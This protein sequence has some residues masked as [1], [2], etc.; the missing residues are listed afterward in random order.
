MFAHGAQQFETADPR[1]AHIADHGVV[2]ASRQLLECLGPAS[3]SKHSITALLQHPTQY[4][5]YRVIVVDEQHPGLRMQFFRIDWGAAPGAGGLLP[6]PHL[7][8]CSSH[9]KLNG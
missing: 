7:A 8:S 5:A 2:A 4:I 3:A 1:H 6:D 9:V